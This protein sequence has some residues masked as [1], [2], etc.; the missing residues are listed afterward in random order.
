MTAGIGRTGPDPDAVIAVGAREQ[1]RQARQ[2]RAARRKKR[3]ALLVVGLSAGSRLLRDRGFQTTVI[4]GAIGAA[5]LASFARES[6]ARTRARL[7]LW[8]HRQ[9]LREQRKAPARR[10]PPSGRRP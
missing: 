4:T 1:A 8:D 6:R 5:A 7:A 9:S 2:A 10:G 3:R